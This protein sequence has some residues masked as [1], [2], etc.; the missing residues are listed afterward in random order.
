MY[1][2]PGNQIHGEVLIGKGV[3][4]RK[5]KKTTVD[6]TLWKLATKVVL[7]SWHDAHKFGVFIV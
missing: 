6:A 2:G 4:K 7:Q 5:K 3:E 1:S